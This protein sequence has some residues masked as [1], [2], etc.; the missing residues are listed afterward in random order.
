MRGEPVTFTPD[1]GGSAALYGFLYQIAHHLSWVADVRLQKTNVDGDEGIVVFEPRSGG[2]AQS[3]G[4][5]YVVEQYKTRNASWSLNELLREVLPDLR[6]AVKSPSAQMASYRFITSGWAGRGVDAFVD[7]TKRI[8]TLPSVDQIDREVV[9]KYNDTFQTDEEVFS[10]TC[11]ETRVRSF[12]GDLAEERSEV[13]HLLSCLEIRWREGMEAVVARVNDALS[14]LFPTNIDIDRARAS[15]IGVLVERMAGRELRMTREQVRDFFLRAGL[16]PDLP[17]KLPLLPSRL[18]AEVASRLGESGYRGN[19]DVRGLLQWPLDRPILVIT[20]ESGNGKSWC[21]AKLISGLAQEDELVTWSAALA[22]VDDQLSQITDSLWSF[23]LQQQ[24][25]RRLAG[26]EAYYRQWTGKQGYWLTVGVDDIFDV[27]MA[28]ELSTRS[29]WKV[30]GARLAISAPTAVADL[31]ATLLPAK[32]HVIHVN[33]FTVDE[34]R[35]FLEKRGRQW[36]ELPDDLKRLLQKPILA[37]LYADLPYSSYV[38]APKSEYEIFNAFWERLRK[39]TLV[40]DVGLLINLAERVM[41]KG[42]YPIARGDWPAISFDAT[43]VQRLAAEGWLQVDRGDRVS[44][45]HDRLMNWAA[46]QAVYSKVEA[47]TLNEVE[48]AQLIRDSLYGASPFGRPLRY[49]AMDVMWLL[50]AT[51]VEWLSIEKVLE[52]IEADQHVASAFYEDLLPTLGEPSIKWLLAR[53]KAV[54]GSSDVR[55]IYIREGLKTLAAQERVDIRGVIFDLLDS[56]VDYLQFIAFQLIPAQPHVEYLTELWEL[57]EWHSRR[58]VTGASTAWCNAL[59]AC[60]SMDPQWLIERI[61]SAGTNPENLSDLGYVLAGLET[62]TAPAIWQEVR[63][64]LVS[65]IAVG[66]ARS[67]LYCVRRFSDTT[68]IQY[69]SDHLGDNADGQDAA[70]LPALARTSPDLAIKNLQ[71]VDRFTR[72]F[73]RNKWLPELLERRKKETLDR[74]ATLFSEGSIDFNELGMLFEPSPDDMG[75]PLL[76]SYLRGLER[77]FDTSESQASDDWLR[78]PL[79]LLA[80]LVDVDH[81]H[82]LR[83]RRGGILEQKIR[84]V[85]ERRVGTTS[86][87]VDGLLEAARM[88]LLKIAGDGIA[89]LI[90]TELRSPKYWGRH[91]GLRW[92]EVAG[93]RTIDLLKA[94]AI[95]DRPENDDHAHDKMELYVALRKLAALHADDQVSDVIWK[96]GAA[97]LPRDLASICGARVMAPHIVDRAKAV[98]ADGDSGEEIVQRALALVW[99]SGAR[100]LLPVVRVRLSAMVPGSLTA[101]I[102]SHL[103][104]RLED[105]SEEAFKFAKRMLASEEGRWLGINLLLAFGDRGLRPLKSHVQAR[106]AASRDHLDQVIIEAIYRDPA[107][108]ESAEKLALEDLGRPFLDPASFDI[109][110]ESASPEA[111]EHVRLAAFSQDRTEV[112]RAVSA[113]RALTRFDRD[114]ALAAAS[115]ELAAGSKTAD[116]VCMAV[117]EMD[118]PALAL[119]WLVKAAITSPEDRWPAIGR[120]FRRLEPRDVSSALCLLG[121]SPSMNERRSALHCGSWCIDP[122]ESWFRGFLEGDPEG[123]VRDEA[124]LGLRRRR[125]LAN[126]HRLLEALPPLPEQQQWAIL[127]AL[128]A[129]TPRQLLTDRRDVLWLGHALDRMPDRFVTF[130]EEQISRQKEVP[131]S[132]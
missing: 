129:S 126:S 79:D 4:V 24:D 69:A 15:L 81:L 28:R 2:D 8:A 109:A 72:H 59:R 76:D 46:A 86:N 93:S 60:V 17:G 9:R 64:E 41:Q 121:Q 38:T 29:E 33:E 88:V 35:S 43:S 26:I 40:G 36:S 125:R 23:G 127:Q 21:L 75:L 1:P 85:A 70:A 131:E 44:F 122:S 16:D 123:K 92:A 58:D 94:I 6:R 49:L 90:A 105:R 82:L 80:G 98:L 91:F 124:I 7:F 71:L 120:G 65:R 14:L 110:A 39:R 97:D 37:R 25:S 45:A 68:M 66:K 3:D 115:Q 67:I 106:E 30:D 87:A 83:M 34:L 96:R 20:G 53:L 55:T 99:V 11:M 47:R 114:S 54:V 108:K 102:A 103:I 130:A 31:L 32:V 18:A 113:F 5:Q 61:R 12:R 119:Q 132:I 51:P 42:S 77:A 78:R 10:R 63:S 101:A 73:V 13:F 62:E 57:R 104:L 95:D 50:A 52:A 117:V 128:I 111:R 118:E 74:V 100:E 89:E 116:S 107:S 27:K 84:R 56:P 112:G 19:E 48:L 22:N